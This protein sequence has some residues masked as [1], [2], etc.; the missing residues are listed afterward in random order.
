MNV[1]LLYGLQASTSPFDVSNPPLILDKEVR[2]TFER[3]ARLSVSEAL[4]GMLQGDNQDNNDVVLSTVYTTNESLYRA[5]KSLVEIH[6]LTPHTGIEIYEFAETDNSSVPN[7]EEIDLEYLRLAT[8]LKHI[9]VNRYV[10]VRDTML[11]MLKSYAGKTLKSKSWNIAGELFDDDD[12]LVTI[13][14]EKPKK[15]TQFYD[16]VQEICPEVTEEDFTAL[17]ESCVNTV[18]KNV[19][20]EESWRDYAYYTADM[21]TVEKVMDLRGHLRPYLRKRNLRALLEVITA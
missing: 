18:I 7:Y 5:L 12:E 9:S 20:G 21:V 19:H 17:F 10:V 16:V 6:F 11:K 3:C 2:Y 13:R 8:K 4:V 1:K 15:F 14:P